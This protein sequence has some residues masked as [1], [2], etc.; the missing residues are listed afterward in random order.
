[1][2]ICFWPVPATAAEITTNGL[3]GGAWSEAATWRG[4]AVP[5]AEDEVTIRKG[6][7]VVFDRNDDGKTTCAK[8]FI[9]PKG[10]L[11]FKTKAGKIVFTT[12]GQIESFGQLKLDGTASADDVHELRLTGKTVE[13]RAIKFEKGGALLVAGKAN[14]PGGKRN[15]FI[16]ALDPD[17]KATEPWSQIDV[18]SGMLDVQRAELHHIKLRG[19]DIDN[20]GTKPG[21]RCNIIAN[22]FLGRCNV[23][24]ENCDTPHANENAFEYPGDPWQQPAALY[25]NGCPLAEVKNNSVKGYFYYAYSFYVCTDCV[26]MGNTSEKCYVGI[27]CVGTAMFKGNTFKDASCGYTV[28]SMSGTIEDDVFERTALGVHL[29]G[30]TIQMTNP[31][32]KDPPKE[33]RLIEF[34]A[35][36]VTLINCDI[37][38]E[39]IS[40]PKTLP[41]PMTDKPLVTSMQFLVLK[42]NGEVP[43]DSVVDI[44]TINPNPPIAPGAADLNIRN[45]PAPLVGGKTPLPLSLSPIALK[46]WVIEKDG[47]TTPAPEYNVRVLAPAEPGKDAKILKTVKV[48]PVGKWRR[49]TPQDATPTLEIDLK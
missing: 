44:R 47:K 5:K 4:G 30:A 19:V 39:L 11:R 9:D 37:G 7:A 24:L 10:A 3:G 20:T 15:V 28:T 36:E 27:Y 17:P 49:P 33:Y 18:K 26:V 2:G 16:T 23:L 8:L 31:V 42:V 34:S 35:G 21:E 25:L 45:A 43:E 40:L 13:D 6:D 14:L 48:R 22:R 12:P 46:G 38:P 1:M 41:M 29:A 32:M